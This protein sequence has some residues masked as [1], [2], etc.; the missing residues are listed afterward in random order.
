MHHI[1]TACPQKFKFLMY[2]FR[3]TLIITAK[4]IKKNKSQSQLLPTQVCGSLHRSQ[5][6]CGTPPLYGHGH[7]LEKK[8]EGPLFPSCL[9]EVA[10]KVLEEMMS[11]WAQHPCCLHCHWDKVVA[12]IQMRILATYYFQLPHLCDTSEASKK[13]NAVET[14]MQFAE[15]MSGT[16]LQYMCTNFNTV[17]T[18]NQ[19]GCG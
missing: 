2:S 3:F 10:S 14:S 19:P 9:P 16:G 11:F 17:L 12:R 13:N 8:L 5:N 4:F 6:C 18:G 1:T 7:T 15:V